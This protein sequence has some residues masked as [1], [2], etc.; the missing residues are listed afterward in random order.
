VSPVLAREEYVEQAYLFRTITERIGQREPL[1]VILKQTREEILATT[2]LPLAIDF[3][4]GEVKLV[5]LLGPAMRR[6]GHYF[7]PFQA[8]LFEQAENEKGRFDM[9]IAL[10]ILRFDAEYRAGTPSP[11]GVFF[12]EFEALCRNRLGYDRGLEAISEDPL[13]DAAWR[14]WV[15]EVR[16]QLGILDIADMVY[17]RSE[18]YL[19]R[20]RITADEM[21]HV[22]LFGEKEGRIA[23]AN[24]QKEPT[25]LF[26]AL[27]RHLGYP[28]VP[29][30][31][32]PREDEALLQ[33]MR[34]K[35]ELLDT[36]IKLLEEEQRAGAVD[37]TKLLPPP[38]KRPPT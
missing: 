22:L 6:I 32:P 16:R 17:V 21:P 31:R 19:T 24:R 20:N 18:H 28:A 10:E 37:L 15:L 5:G 38:G 33:E 11:A 29:R 12:Y 8:Y 35:I 30:P 25:F 36:R 3:L 27:Q 26:A 34:R 1:Q 9:R 4:L 14:E 23:V 7:H 2:R 13:F